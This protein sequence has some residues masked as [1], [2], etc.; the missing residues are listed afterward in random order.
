VSDSGKGREITDE[1][2]P[3]ARI[4][5]EIGEMLLRRPCTASEI[6]S[7]LSLNSEQAAE[8]LKNMEN[9]GCLTVKIHGGKKYYR[10]AVG[11]QI[12]YE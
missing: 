12:Q 4:E 3:P 6:A 2:I 5:T 9:R 7:A 1:I 8:V 10:T 11:E